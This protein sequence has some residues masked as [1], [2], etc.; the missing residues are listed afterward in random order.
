[1][2]YFILI[3]LWCK[4]FFCWLPSWNQQCLSL[5]SHQCRNS[6]GW[7]YISILFVLIQFNLLKTSTDAFQR[8][9][10]EKF[11]FLE[12]IFHKKKSISFCWF[13]LFAR[14]VVREKQT[15]YEYNVKDG[16]LIKCTLRAGFSLLWRTWSMNLIEHWT[17]SKSLISTITKLQCNNIKEERVQVPYW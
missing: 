3:L 14:P 4:F 8:S 6:A 12:V 15:F 9:E 10:K 13:S 16:V 1:M 17:S 5:C 2:R 11:S 7:S